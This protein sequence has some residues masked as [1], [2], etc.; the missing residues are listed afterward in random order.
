MVNGRREGEKGFLTEVH[1]VTQRIDKNM[2]TN[3][4]VVK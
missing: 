3:E 2:R 4:E 1:K